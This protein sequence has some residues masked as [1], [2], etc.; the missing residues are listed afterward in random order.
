MFIQPFIIALLSTLA[1]SYRLLEYSGLECAGAQEGVFRLAGPSACTN[2]D[3]GKSE[4]VLV[5]IDNVYD[6]QYTVEFYTDENCQGLVQ[7]EVS[8]S[9]SCVDI[10]SKFDASQNV[11][12]VRV[13][14]RLPG[15]RS[16]ESEDIM[17][18]YGYSDD[19]N[20]YTPIA[21]GVFLPINMSDIN[22]DG[23]FN[24]PDDNINSF[25]NNTHINTDMTKGKMQDLDYFTERDL[26]PALCQALQ[27]CIEDIEDLDGYG[28]V[29]WAIRMGKRLKA[30]PWKKFHNT[31]L[32]AVDQLANGATLYSSFTTTGTQSKKCDTDYD[33][34]AL[35]EDAM[36]QEASMDN[37]TN[38][39]MQ[40]CSE[41]K[42][43]FEFAEFLYLKN[44][45]NNGSCKIAG[46]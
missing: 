45:H 32:I 38:L 22:A 2:L 33:T 37:Y 6:D 36:K 19:G 28:A 25:I 44:K 34:G 8:N 39:I 29:K 35:V 4:S 17:M 26:T 41:D 23:T 11:K 31:A 13:Q 20:H 10:F 43:C 7:R 40:F 14:N 16:I 3:Y 15:K 9:N 5:K 1:H 46:T 24:D 27:Q 18:D 12:S 21:P 42:A 30:L